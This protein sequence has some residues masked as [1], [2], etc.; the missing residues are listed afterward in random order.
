MKISSFIV[1]L[2]ITAL[3]LGAHA[4]APKDSAAI[5]AALKAN[6][7][8]LD[9]GPDSR[10]KAMVIFKDAITEIDTYLKATPE[11]KDKV[12]AQILKFQ[13]LSATGQEEIDALKL[14]DL[15]QQVAK[16]K[17]G[18]LETAIPLIAMQV[19]SL[20][21]KGDKKAATAS[22]D[23]FEKDFADH[24]DMEKQGSRMIAS[25]RGKLNQPATGDAMEIAFT[26]LD[27]TKV[28]L[29]AMKG[30]VVLVDFWATWC[31]PCVGE[32][33][34]VKKAFDTYHAKG[35]EIIAI[36][37]DQEKD[38]LEAFI[39]KEN[40]TWPQA[41]DG[42]GWGSDIARKFGINSIPATFLIGKDG[43]VAATNLRGSALEEKVAELLK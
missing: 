14:A 32:L 29:A 34:N 43:K 40:M 5:E 21:S 15:Y 33:P 23:A 37:L 38:A 30:K 39:K 24:P 2:A 12:K 31:G 13:L 35:F 1:A 41:F 28:D 27:G 17:D 10:E 7:S 11:A 26:A 4:E 42:K 3:T 36:S 16:G 25:M 9:R 20:L 18:D 6:L 8:K 19:R 22:L